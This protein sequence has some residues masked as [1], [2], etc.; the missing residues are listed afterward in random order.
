MA[1]RRRRV[2]RDNLPELGISALL[3]GCIGYFQAGVIG[4]WITGLAFMAVCAVLLPMAQ[5]EGEI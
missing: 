4:A 2:I 3:G 1:K 5:D